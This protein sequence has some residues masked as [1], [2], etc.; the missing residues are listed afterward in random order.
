MIITCKNCKTSFYVAHGARVEG[1]Q[2]RCSHCT[3]QWVHKGKTFIKK[4]NY[5]ILQ[6]TAIKSKRRVGI[7]T[8][9]VVAIPTLLLAFTLFLSTIFFQKFFTT[10][11]P[12]L[13]SY[14]EKL[15]LYSID[16]YVI[17]SVHAVKYEDGAMING[18]IENNATDA[19]K[20]PAL[21]VK[22]TY[23][24]FIK[25]QTFLI[26][27]SNNVLRPHEKYF[28]SQQV[29]LLGAP[30]QISVEIMDTLEVLFYKLFRQ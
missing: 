29:Y 25:P 4:V 7:L 20:V 23:S 30:Q 22:I 18:A 6:L 2:V 24:D 14:Y 11:W 1:R 9:P 26:A 8:L 19:R 12:I 5:N 17:H 3:H 15:G 10:R 13:N 28:F 21:L 27:E 16:D